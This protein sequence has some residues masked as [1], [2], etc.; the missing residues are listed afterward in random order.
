MSTFAQLGLLN[1]KQLFN[2]KL[3]EGSTVF[4]L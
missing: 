3:I 1:N 2:L 4:D